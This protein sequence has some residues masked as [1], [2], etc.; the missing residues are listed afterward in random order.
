LRKGIDAVRA[1]FRVEGRLDLVPGIYEIQGT[2][3]LA[4]PPQVGTW[5]GTVAV[6]P[7]SKSSTPAI[8]GP[9]VT[10]DG[11]A[12]APLL[13]QPSVQEAA[14]PLSVKSGIRFLP[15]SSMDFPTEQSLLAMFWL[16][17]FAPPSDKPPSIEMSVT[18]IDAGGGQLTAPSELVY[19]GPSPA[20]GF[21]VIARVNCS[22]VPSG[23][24]LVQVAA[25]PE[26]GSSPLRR[27]S[28]PFTLNPRDASPAPPV[29]TSSAP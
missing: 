24:Y 28:A 4:S 25:T 8:L 27:R 29:A 7:Q 2:I 11:P 3:R 23:T 16:K 26:G 13:S 21:S 10:V 15:A 17:D 20:G 18:L 6:P 19:F 22:K 12:A 1:G 5:T 14:D 9:I